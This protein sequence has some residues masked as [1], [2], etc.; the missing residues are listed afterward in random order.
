MRKSAVLVLLASALFM[1]SAAMAADEDLFSEVEAVCSKVDAAESLTTEELNSLIE[2]VD[3][4]VSRVE[5]S[6]HPKKKLYLFRLQK[7]RGIYA[8]IIGLRAPK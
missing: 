1:S 7:C 2:S 6:E 4:L 5:A 8:Y 3:R